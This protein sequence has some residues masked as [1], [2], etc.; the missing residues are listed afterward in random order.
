MVSLVV[1]GIDDD[2]G[3]GGRGGVE[4]SVI[5]SQTMSND[6]MLVKACS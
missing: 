4:S 3:G 2:G 5:D 1:G 6:L